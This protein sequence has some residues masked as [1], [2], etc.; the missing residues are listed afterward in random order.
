MGADSGHI[1]G[2]G[3]GRLAGAVRGAQFGG[4]V[5]AGARPR[6]IWPRSIFWK[7]AGGVKRSA[8][9]FCA[10]TF[11]A[12]SLTLG[13]PSFVTMTRSGKA[14]VP[15]SV[16]SHDGPNAPRRPVAAAAPRP[17]KGPSWSVSQASVTVSS[18]FVTYLVV[19]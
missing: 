13:L 12:S 8:G 10:S 4:G 17:R 1:G 11:V 9:S 5:A 6:I 2:S 18:C 15:S 7:S 19:S 16:W 14:L 3:I